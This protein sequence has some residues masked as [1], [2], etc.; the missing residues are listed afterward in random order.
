MLSSAF[1]IE[2]LINLFANSTEC[3]KA[4]FAENRNIFD[5]LIV[6]VSL[7]SIMLGAMGIQSLPAVKMLRLIRGIRL[8]SDIEPTRLVAGLLVGLLVARAV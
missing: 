2:L 1:T 3:F 5:A 8:A 7:V 4:F 6:L